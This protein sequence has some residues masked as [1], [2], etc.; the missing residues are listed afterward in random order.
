MVSI[1]M[2][3]DE[4]A[5]NPDI[6]PMLFILTDGETNRG[7][8]FDSVEYLIKGVKIPIYTIG[9]NANITILQKVSSINEAANINA[10]TDDVIYKIGSFFNS[11]M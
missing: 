5:N 8:G 6:R 10:E 7:M 11:Q 1:K 3:I 4:K 2:L 9:Y